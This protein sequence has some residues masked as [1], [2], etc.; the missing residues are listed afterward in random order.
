LAES[1]AI[2][3]Q[4]ASRTISVISSRACSELNPRPTNRSRRL[5]GLVESL[6]TASYHQ[7]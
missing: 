7:T 4:E 5:P 3:G 2:T 6:K 1:N